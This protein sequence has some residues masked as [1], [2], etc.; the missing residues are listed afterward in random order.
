MITYTTFSGT[1]PKILS[2]QY[3]SV[4]LILIIIFYYLLISIVVVKY[5]TYTIYM[6]KDLQLLYNNALTVRCSQCVTNGGRMHFITVTSG[7]KEGPLSSHF[8]SPCLPL[9]NY[10]SKQQYHVAFFR[11]QSTYAAHPANEMR[12]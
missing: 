6:Q 9:S 1:I 2:L 5:N 4:S 3:L 11:D 8:T 12:F 7:F 10:S